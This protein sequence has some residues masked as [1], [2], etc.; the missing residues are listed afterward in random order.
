MAIRRADSRFRRWS[1]FLPVVFLVQQAALGRVPL[2]GASA[3]HGHGPCSR[4]GEQC[5]SH[6]DQ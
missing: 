2:H 5:Q 4:R 6:G 3:R 1:F